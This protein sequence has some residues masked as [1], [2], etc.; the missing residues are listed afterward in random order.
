MVVMDVNTIHMTQDSQHVIQMLPQHQHLAQ[1]RMT[2]TMPMF[3]HV[4]IVV[5]Q[6]KQF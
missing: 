1:H 4:M 2:I 5:G 3:I 6:L